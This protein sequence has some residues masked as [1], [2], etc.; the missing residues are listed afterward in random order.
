[1]ENFVQ[2]PFPRT[3]KKKKKTKQFK[4]F[5]KEKVLYVKRNLKKNI[6]FPKINLKFGAITKESNNSLK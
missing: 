5:Q 1:M 3:K 2:N 6:R 4:T